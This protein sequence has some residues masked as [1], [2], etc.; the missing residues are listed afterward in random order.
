MKKAY[1]AKYNKNLSLASAIEK[2]KNLEENGCVPIEYEVLAEIKCCQKKIKKI[3]ESGSINGISEIAILGIR[4]I[5]NDK[6]TWECIVLD[7]PDES[8]TLY[9]GGTSEVMYYSIKS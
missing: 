9:T 2:I 3:I 7:G 4:S 6:G 8:L 1:F 5:Q